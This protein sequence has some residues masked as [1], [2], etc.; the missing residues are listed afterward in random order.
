MKIAKILIGNPD[1]RKGFFNNVIERTK[2]LIEAEP[3]VCCYIIRH[4]YGV[5]LRLLKLQ[6]RRPVREEYSLIDNILFKNLWLKVGFFD[7]LMT[8]RF[9]KKLTVG[10][11]QLDRYVP[12]FSKYDLI[13]PHGLS[14]IYLSAKVKKEY[15]IPF[16]PTWH[17][18]DINVTPF[19]SLSTKKKVKNLIDKAD[20]NFFVSQA[21]LNKSNEI[22]FESQSSVLYTGPAKSFAKHSVEMRRVTRKKYGIST[23]K[24][25]GFVGNLVSIK[26][27]LILPFIFKKIQDEVPDIS[28][29]VVGDGELT[30]RL[31]SE[32][33]KND[34]NNLH[35]LGALP[36]SEMPDI[37]S[38]LD[39]LV[40]PSLNEGLPRVTLEAQA[41]S[42]HV[43]GSD[44]GGIPEAIGD[45]NCFPL[46]SSFVKNISTRAIEMLVGEVARPTLPVVYSWDK[47]IERELSVY[48]YLCL[49]K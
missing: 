11:S 42:V 7:Y 47:A 8:H 45:E 14:A 34:V 22:S 36:P 3:D 25:V 20:H 5:I 37:M 27:V 15:Q 44:R 40:L 35:L 18:S 4:E 26:N 38:C 10:M 41:C 39:I 30:N 2:H 24:V 12:L 23:D 29:V 6:F 16:V 32:F 19:R 48:N 9:N 46:G 1:N 17:G 13:S 31:S 49:S 28:F 33:K 21:L 43:V